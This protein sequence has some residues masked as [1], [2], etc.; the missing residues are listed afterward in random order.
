MKPRALSSV[1]IAIHVHSCFDDP[2]F[3][4]ELVKLD[5]DL[6]SIDNVATRESRAVWDDDVAVGSRHSEAGRLLIALGGFFALM[7][8]GAGVAA[9]V[10]HDRLA[11]LLR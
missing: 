4:T 9:A 11:L 1:G 2:A 5:D 7:C 8:I 10:F 3:F 6:P